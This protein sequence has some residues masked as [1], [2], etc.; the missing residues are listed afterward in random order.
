MFQPPSAQELDD[1]GQCVCICQIYGAP[2]IVSIE[3][4]YRHLRDAGTEEEREKIRSGRVLR[5]GSLP[6]QSHITSLQP[7]ASGSTTRDV[8][9]PPNVRNAAIAD[10]LAR[11]DEDD[12]AWRVG[13]RKRARI[14][15]THPADA[16]QLHNVSVREPFQ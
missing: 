10:A 9:E 12:T 14:S 13:R 16:F 6:P 8:S 3:T 1:T 7:V 2:H 15:K 5:G 4:W 11:E